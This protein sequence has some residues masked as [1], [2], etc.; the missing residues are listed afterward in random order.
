MSIKILV[1]HTTGLI[2]KSTTVAS[3]L[4]PRLK[5]ARVFSVE[6]QNQDASRYGISVD[7]YLP[8]DIKKLRENTV[9]ETNNLIVDVGSSQ[10][11]EVVKEFGRLRGS[12]NDFDVVI[13]PTIPD[14]R[15][16]EETLTTIEGLRKVGLHPE[17]LRILFNKAT[18]EPDGP[19][20]A[21]FEDILV[22]LHQHQELPFY[23]DLVLYDN[24]IHSD[25]RSE[26]LSFETVL[27]DTTDY[28]TAVKEAVKNAPRSP[29][30]LRLVRRM[31]L[32]L[33]VNSAQR[34]LDAAFVA[35][36]LP[37]VAAEA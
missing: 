21:E 3:L 1:I 37:T 13:V 18:I 10:Y 11:A 17:K 14:Q 26:G 22:Y 32:Q 30:T 8:A 31:G 33:A 6:K 15:A 24:P 25:L 29:E 23:E 28:R 12:I 20:E 4:H 35:L 7:V 19:L 36:R 5:D 34:D 9:L 16:Q 27:K 2:G